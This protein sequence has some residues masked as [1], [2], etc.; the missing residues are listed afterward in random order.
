LAQL[1][2]VSQ[3]RSEELINY[4]EQAI[5]ENPKCDCYINGNPI[6]VNCDDIGDVD[7][8]EVAE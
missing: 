5:K 3:S 1:H 4:L 8:Y 6:G 2:I 7:L